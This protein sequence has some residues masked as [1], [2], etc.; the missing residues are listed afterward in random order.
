[1]SLTV[2]LTLEEFVAFTLPHCSYVDLIGEIPS[3]ISS[4]LRAPC[5]GCSE[6]V[7]TTSK[8]KVHYGR[9]L[10]QTDLIGFGTTGGKGKGRAA[11]RVTKSRQSDL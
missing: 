9:G 7:I 2:Y 3:G 6:D 4:E 5:D 10:F 8:P 11:K 1:M